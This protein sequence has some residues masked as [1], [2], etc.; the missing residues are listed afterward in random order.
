MP[1]GGLIRKTLR[2]SAPAVTSETSLG[3]RKWAEMERSTAEAAKGVRQRE[4]MLAIHTMSDHKY[5]K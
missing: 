5:L 4:N 3:E 1:V 2:M